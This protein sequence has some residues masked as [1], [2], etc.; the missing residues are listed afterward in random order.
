MHIHSTLLRSATLLMVA[1]LCVPAP[2]AEGSGI[3]PGAYTIKPLH[4]QQYPQRLGGVP[5]PITQQEAFVGLVSESWSADKFYIFPH[6][7]GGHVIANNPEITS[8][9]TVARGVVLGAPRIDLRACDPAPAPRSRCD[10]GVEDQRFRFRRIS[11]NIY[12]IHTLSQACWDVRG[13]G[14]SDRTDVLAS[15]CNSMGHQR[16]ELIR[17]PAERSAFIEQCDRER[18][19]SAAKE[20]PQARAVVAQPTT[21]TTVF[22]GDTPPTPRARAPF[23]QNRDRPGNDL[24]ASAGGR[25]VGLPDA[26]ACDFACNNSTKACKAWT[27]VKPGFQGTQSVCYLKH[28]VTPS[29]SNDCCV[30]SVK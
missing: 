20:P 14:R 8:C 26:A 23:E 30:T 18:G 2:A 25:I 12:E 1:L 16:F 24:P 5:P 27:F 15:D 22:V 17:L 28:T 6:R 3:E 10:I 7:D 19:W 13:A 21:T 9:A 29:V 11:G 4:V